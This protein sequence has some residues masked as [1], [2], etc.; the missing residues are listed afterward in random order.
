MTFSIKS[1]ARLMIKSCK[2]IGSK[3]TI[4][5]EIELLSF[6]TKSQL[7]R[8]SSTKNLLISSSNLSY[9]KNFI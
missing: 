5:V 7:L 2:A 8:W 4:Q 1:Q 6:K 3:L 9:L